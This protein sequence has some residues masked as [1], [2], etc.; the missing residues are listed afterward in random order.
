M[1]GLLL[2]FS[3]I[4]AL[5]PLSAEGGQSEIS[6]LNDS[7]RVTSYNI[8]L[9]KDNA[10]FPFSIGIEVETEEASSAEAGVSLKMQNGKA[11]NKENFRVKWECWTAK[12]IKLSMSITPLRYTGTDTASHPDIH[13]TLSGKGTV[14]SEGETKIS[15]YSGKTEAFEFYNQSVSKFQKIT[16]QQEL[17]IET[18]NLEGVYR[19]I[20]EGNI[21]VKIE[22]I[23]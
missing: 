5:C 7:G 20:Y 10:P 6:A 23:G 14:F 4:I 21:T 13:W 15:I 1:K 9:T 16:D 19:G 12:G 11:V 22:P 8:D 2:F 18:D 17:G 3:L